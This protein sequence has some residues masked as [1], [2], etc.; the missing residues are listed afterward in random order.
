ML[1]SVLCSRFISMLG[2]LCLIVGGC[3]IRYSLLTALTRPRRKPVLRQ[4]ILQLSFPTKSFKIAGPSTGPQRIRRGGTCTATGHRFA[5]QWQIQDITF[6]FQHYALPSLWYIHP[7]NVPDVPGRLGLERIVCTSQREYV[8]QQT[9]KRII[10]VAIDND[11]LPA[12]HRISTRQSRE[13]W[14]AYTR[15]LLSSPLVC[16]SDAFIRTE[17]G[18]PGSSFGRMKSAMCLYRKDRVASGPA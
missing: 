16:N 8:V 6:P 11:G 2:S 3:A 12:H 13:E 15:G 7:E 9:K 4:W 10:V 1:E 17:F 18:I 14:D 5:E